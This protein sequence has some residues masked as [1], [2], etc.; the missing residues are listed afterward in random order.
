MNKDQF[1]YWLK[2]FVDAV[3]VSPTQYQWGIILDKLDDIKDCPDFGSP[4]GVGGWGTSNNL[5]LWKEPHY[6]NQL[7]KY[8]ITC[9]GSGSGTVSGNVSSG[10]MGTTGIISSRGGTSSG[11]HSVVT[12]EGNTSITTTSNPLSTLTTGNTTTKLFPGTTLNYTTNDSKD[13]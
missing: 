8:K 1:I 11:N 12:T 2:G 13:S 6:P 9:E 3:E 7:D 4:I 5:P 10:I